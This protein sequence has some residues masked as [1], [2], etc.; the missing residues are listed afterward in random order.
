MRRE[1]KVYFFFAFL[2]VFFA[3]AFAFFFVA[4][5]SLL[6][7]PYGWS[8]EGE[9]ASGFVEPPR[10]ENDSTNLLIHYLDARVHPLV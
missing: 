4:I 1:K 5:P 6:N 10:C 8:P 7:G 3:A 2:A 9:L